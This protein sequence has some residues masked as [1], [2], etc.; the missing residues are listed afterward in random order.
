MYIVL[1]ILGE[2]RRRGWRAGQGFCDVGTCTTLPLLLNMWGGSLTGQ[3]DVAGLVELASYI[4]PFCGY[5]ACGAAADGLHTRL[6]SWVFGDWSP[7]APG[8]PPLPTRFA[9]TDVVCFYYRSRPFEAAAAHAVY[10][11]PSPLRDPC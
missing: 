6:G 11:P 10:P 9:F 3:S 1:R 8:T 7:S 2:L 5:P 4:E